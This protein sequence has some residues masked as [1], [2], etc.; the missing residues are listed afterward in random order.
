MMNII[1]QRLFEILE[2]P[3]EYLRS[4]EKLIF[5]KDDMRVVLYNDGKELSMHKEEVD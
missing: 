5:E 2:N 3:Y 4:G 1:T